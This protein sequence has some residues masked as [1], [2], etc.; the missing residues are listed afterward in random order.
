MASAGNKRG[1]SAWEDCEDVRE[2]K[3]HLSKQY[4]QIES[5]RKEKADLTKALKLAE[6][7]APEETPE[8]LNAQARRI[9]DTLFIKLQ[10]SD[11]V[12][13]QAQFIQ[14]CS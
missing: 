2:L 4:D 8:E 5:L 10:R 9:R 12:S 7:Q 13:Q 3:G 1:R 6:G 11:G 14:N